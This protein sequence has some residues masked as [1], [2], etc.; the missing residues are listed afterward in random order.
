MRQAMKRGTFHRRVGP[1]S[2]AVDLTSCIKVEGPGFGAARPCGEGRPWF[3]WQV[4]GP[5]AL[6]PGCRMCTIARPH[7]IMGRRMQMCHNPSKNATPNAR[8]ALREVAL[9]VEYLHNRKLLHCDIKPENVLLKSDPSRALGFVCKWVPRPARRALPT[10]AVAARPVPRR[11][12]ASTRVARAAPAGIRPGSTHRSPPR[13][14]RA[15]DSH[16]E[17]RPQTSRR[18]S[19]PQNKGWRTLAWSR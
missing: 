1:Q 19:P 18:S 5:G 10:G 15:R 2:L 11:A 9:A 3:G 17:P 7:I 6:F 16:S 8:Q 13:A 12:S 14:V 4:F